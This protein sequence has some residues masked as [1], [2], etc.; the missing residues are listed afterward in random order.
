MKQIRRSPDIS[1]PYLCH[2]CAQVLCGRARQPFSVH[3][4]VGGGMLS[5]P[6]WH[7]RSSAAVESDA[8]GVTGKSMFSAIPARSADPCQASA[9]AT[10]FAHGSSRGALNLPLSGIGPMPGKAKICSSVYRRRCRTRSVSLT[11]GAVQVPKGASLLAELSAKLNAQLELQK[12]ISA[13]EPRVPVRY[14]A[15]SRV[16]TASFQ[17]CCQA[18]LSLSR[19]D[20]SRVVAR[21]SS[22]SGHVDSLN[23]C[24]P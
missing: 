6:S 2:A 8:P 10:G 9:S 5:G 21:S 14:R 3:G 24:G 13:P 17:H 7:R 11:L 4:A 1:N 16:N 20:A 22:R 19:D 18:D 12:H 15:G 23:P